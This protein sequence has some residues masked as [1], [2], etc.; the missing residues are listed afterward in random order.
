MKTRIKVIEKQNG[1]VVYAAQVKKHWLSEWQ[2]LEIASNGI[3]VYNYCSDTY[4]TKTKAEEIIDQYI[5]Q[6][7]AKALS[8]TKKVTYIKYP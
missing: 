1:S 7:A 2:Y 3:L 5:E 8:K 4:H 6:I